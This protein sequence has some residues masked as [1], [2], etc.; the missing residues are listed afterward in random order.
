M[1]LCYLVKVEHPKMLLTLITFDSM[2]TLDELLTC[3]RGQFE[4]LIQHLTVVRQT[5]SRLLTLTD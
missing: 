4:H 2:S 1:L 3:S 5:V